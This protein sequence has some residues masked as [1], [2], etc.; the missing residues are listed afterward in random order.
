PW[1]AQKTAAFVIC[2]P[3]IFLRRLLK[4]YWRATPALTPIQLM[5]CFGVVSCSEKSRLLI[6]HAIFCCLPVCRTPFP[7]KPSIVCVD[8]LCRHYTQLPLTSV[9]GR[10]MFI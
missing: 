7:H 3:M 10:A 9:R 6:L 1:G 8:L 4:V 5:I 2:G